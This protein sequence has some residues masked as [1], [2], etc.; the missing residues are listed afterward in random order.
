MDPFTAMAL[1]Q[2]VGG[3]ASGISANKA[4]KEQARAEAARAQDAID[5]ANQDAELA[6][7]QRAE[8]GL[9][10]SFNQLRSLV[11]QD[12]TSDFLR[13]QAM[14]SEAGQ[15]A[16]LKAGGARAL[17]G[18]T[19]GV[20][21]ATMDRMSKIAQDEQIRKQ[22][23]L[24]VVGGA[25]QRVAENRLADARTDLGL[26]RGQRAE[27]QAALFGAQDL[28]RARIAARNQA[29][30]D[31]GKG[32]ATAAYS[33]FGNDGAG[34]EGADAELMKLFFE[35][36]GLVRGKTPGKFS[37]RENPIDIVQ[38]GEKIGEMTGGEGVIS[39]ED[40]G[41]L[42]QLAGEGKSPLHSYVMELIRKLER[43]GGE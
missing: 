40:L 31:A 6:K 13:Q 1:I 43:N 22:Q 7:R 5:K 33:K 10:P 12:P 18:G 32:L 34:F 16:A 29:M 26:A 30:I 17:L 38:D 36:G 9:G 42:E 35:K 8:Y 20:A 37:H 11:L 2:G 3:I 15:V 39:P 41:K 19:Q 24:A 23:G 25:E 28:D 14:R 21:Q 4:A 27:A